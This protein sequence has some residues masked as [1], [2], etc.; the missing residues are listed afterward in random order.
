MCTVQI[1]LSIPIYDIKVREG[2]NVYDMGAVV[3]YI[4]T[5]AAAATT[6]TN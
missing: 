4:F 5:V 6:H 3:E 1:V 2:Y